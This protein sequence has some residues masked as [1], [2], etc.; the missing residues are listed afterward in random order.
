MKKIFIYL[1]IVA[2]I[3]GCT[4]N[5]IV[6]KIEKNKEG[7]IQK[8]DNRGLYYALPKNKIRIQVPIIKNTQELG[9][10]NKY[11][12]ELLGDSLYYKEQDNVESP[13]VSY[14]ISKP[15][16]FIDAV[17]DEDNIYYVET[18]ANYNKNINFTLTLNENGIIVSGDAS[19]AGKSS[20][21]VVK[22]L[23]T[24]ASIVGKVIGLGKFSISSSSMTNFKNAVSANITNS[25]MK[26][27]NFKMTALV[28]ER[29]LAG[30]IVA[31]NQLKTTMKKNIKN[32]VEVI[33]Q[34]HL[35]DNN[36]IHSYKSV[37]S[38]VSEMTRK[39]NILGDDAFQK[40]GRNIINENEMQ[41]IV[42]E[43]LSEADRAHVLADKLLKIIEVKEK[44]LMLSGKKEGESNNYDPDAI[45]IILNELKTLET[46]YL[47]EFVWSKKD[48]Q[49][50]SIE[51]ELPDLD[52]SSDPEKPLFFI[53]KTGN[54]II[55]PAM[56]EKRLLSQIPGGY[57]SSVEYTNAMPSEY[58]SKI[59]YSIK[60]DT[61]YKLPENI[62][63]SCPTT[64]EHSFCYR[65]PGRAAIEINLNDALLFK[66]NVFIAQFGTELCLPLKTGGESGKSVFTLFNNTG[67]LKTV[68]VNAEVMSSE[69]IGKVGNAAGGIIDQ[70]SALK[71]KIKEKEEET[72]ESYVKV[73][74]E[75]NKKQQEE[76]QKSQEA[77]D[78]KN[79]LTREKEL[80]ELKKAIRDLKSDLGIE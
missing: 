28:D 2:L 80:L 19:V 13:R 44:L 20:E 5:L 39:I 60:K 10:Y 69:N 25:I 52:G 66:E 6:K 68:T 23:E 27:I 7:S 11:F 56:F 12:K 75:Y 65:I 51:F 48:P 46:K 55:I 53:S 15:V 4:N 59:T 77:K 58:V 50:L 30:N 1:S 43:E 71:E 8:F 70:V 32:P 62:K 35:A 54:K 31:L 29:K 14:V 42:I 72:R 17:P 33:V 61:S 3:N 16:V 78:E 38:R 74:E 9:I 37:K 21:Y 24:V 40:L 57:F 22:G 45:T 79:I 67:A 47:A 34:S 41:K 36:R 76:Y 49:P 26:E 73:V 64:G 63:E 18:D